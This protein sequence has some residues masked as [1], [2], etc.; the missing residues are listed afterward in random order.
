M[1][2]NKLVAELYTLQQKGAKNRTPKDRYRLE[3]L[4]LKK[5]ADDAH[6]KELELKA[7]IGEDFLRHVATQSNTT[8]DWLNAVVNE[9]DRWYAE[10]LVNTYREEAEKKAV[11]K[12][13]TDDENQDQSLSETAAG[14]QQ[15]QA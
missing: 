3:Q 8:D 13:E 15:D 11:A 10:M 1:M 12:A 9:T 14:V 2:S 7:H 6:Q 5:S 4:K